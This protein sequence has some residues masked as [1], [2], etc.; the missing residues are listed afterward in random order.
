MPRRRLR[1]SITLF[2]GRTTAKY[3]AAATSRKLTTAVSR[4]PKR[5]SLPLRVSTA[6]ESKFGEPTTAETI[7]TSTASTRAVTF[8]PKAAPMITATARSSTLPFMMKSLSISAD[9]PQ[10]AGA[11]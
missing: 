10:G 1:A 3:T 6:K 5:S 8:C 7:G 9:H 11:A 4:T 2:T